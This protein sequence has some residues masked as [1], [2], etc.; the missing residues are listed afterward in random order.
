[1]EQ[2]NTQVNIDRI[3]LRLM[4][5]D[6]LQAARRLLLLGLIIVILFSAL[7]AWRTYSS[8]TPTYQASASFIVT[9]TNPLYNE[10]K[11]Y[12]DTY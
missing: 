7:F 1:M 3:D 10:I 6:F 4:L 11:T 8:Y 12:Q 5:A 9:V 2:E